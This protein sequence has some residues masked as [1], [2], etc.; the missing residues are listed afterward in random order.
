MTIPP[1]Y[2]NPLLPVGERVAD[3]LGR[4][5][6]AD[7]AGLL[8]HDMAVSGP[9]GT[10]VGDDNFLGR[11]ATA[12]AIQSLRIN[13]FSMLGAVTDLRSHVRWHNA[14][15]EAAMD[16]ELG[17]PVS[18]ST[19]PRHGFD[20]NPGT[21]ADAGVFSRWPESLGFAALRDPSTLE[22]YAD[23]VRREYL[24]AGIRVALHPQVD[25]AT[26][27]RWSRIGLTFGEDADLASELVRAYLRGLHT[28]SFGA[29][30]I[31]AVV[32]HFPGGGPQKDGEDPHF[33]HGREQVYP[34][35]NFDY[36]LKPFIAAIEAGARQIMPYYGMP[37]GTPYDEVGFGFNR[38]IITELLRDQLGF[39]G[40][41][42][43]DWGLL[44]D[45]MVFGEPMPARAWGLERLSPRSRML[46]AIDAGVDQFGGE[47]STDLLIDL[48]ESGELS[49]DR[50]DASVARLLTEKFELGL[51]EN[52]II[53]EDFAVRTVGRADFVE[54]GSLAQ[55]AAMVPLVLAAP[56]QGRV[57]LENIA[58]PGGR[59][60]DSVAAVAEA[61]HAVLRLRAPF[62]PRPGVFESFFH[63]GSLAFDPVE[64]DRIVQ[65]CAAVPT[66]IV[67]YLDRPAVIPEIA[68]A[69]RSLFVEF[70]AS[71]E[72][73]IDVILN[74]SVARG[75]LPFDLP[76]SMAAVEASRSDV[77]FDTAHP[78]FRFGQ[79]AAG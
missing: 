42:V 5:T 49:I 68:S 32:K 13:H 71:D 39:D 11:P 23:V 56:T 67:M 9:D 15:Q 47:S 55:R 50:V 33:A 76:S 2:R 19:D 10:L 6:L 17:I 16:T 3:L 64:R 72:A 66:T 48:V 74:P 30:S 57:Y 20:S 46:A 27:P 77:P 51:F 60:G 44:T 43:A 29:S 45:R 59:L 24:A 12:D 73:V 36:H 22:A 75:R 18:L 40:I 69:A 37:V 58:D 1:P 34:G 26:E 4:M 25:L 52:P 35:D 41:V 79:G 53:D 54:S 31:S 8:F 65:I 63:A 70:G 28:D 7:K 38:G 62:E 78:L 21:S 14:L 61:D